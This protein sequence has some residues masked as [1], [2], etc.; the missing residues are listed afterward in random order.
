[1]KGRVLQEKLSFFLKRNHMFLFILYFA[2]LETVFHISTIGGMWNW[3]GI[4]ILLFSV[5]Y[6]VVWLILGSFI[7]HPV[8]NRIF[9]V[10]LLIAGAFPYGVLYFIYCKFHVFYNLNTVFGGAADAMGGF[11]S[12]IWELIL[13]V[14]GITH[15]VLL[16]LP[17]VLYLIFGIRKDYAQVISGR[18]RVYAMVFGMV[19]FSVAMVLVEQ[20]DVAQASFSEQ[21]SYPGAVEQFGLITGMGLDIQHTTKE[22]EAIDF[23]VEEIVVETQVESSDK[24][25]TTELSKEQESIEY[26]KNVLDIDFEALAKDAPEGLAVLDEYVASLEPSSKNQYTGMFKGKN[27][28]FLTA[29]AFSA[30]VIDEKL[31]PTLY[32]MATKGI[33][34]T[35]YYQPASAGTTG[36][37]YSNIMGLLPTAG[38]RSM[39]DTAKNLNYMTIGSQLNRLGYYGK[40]YHNNDYKYY[41][42]DK[43]HVTLGYSDGYM[44]YGNG[45]EEYVTNQWPESDLEMI[46]GT[47]PTYVNKQPFN[48][49]YMTVSGHSNYS[50]GC[51]A[52]AKK[53]QEQV[54]SLE[55]SDT[56]K[57]YFACQLELEDALTYLVDEL[58]KAGIAEDT[59]I[60]IATDHFPYGLDQNGNSGKLPYL[61]ELYGCDI[62]DDFVKDHNRLILWSECLEKDEPIVVSE[63]TFSPDIVPTLCNL[64]GVEYDSR[65]L[66]GRDVLSDAQPLVFNLGYDWKTDKGTYLAGKNRFTPV[67][68]TT[69]IPEDYVENMKTIVKNKINYCKGVLKQDY[70]SHVFSEDKGGE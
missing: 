54:V 35:D 60:C 29:E 11:S 65:L 67:S 25:E 24:E 12:D 33:N 58:E 22:G 66:P 5:V 17:C 47:L 2:Y 56:V 43:T 18:Q 50:F 38:G 13:S 1:M 69:Y 20:N 8:W 4:Y 41:D 51:N 6:G 28:I 55:Y 26:G 32:R 9:K 46:Q 3:S 37:E 49:Y 52:M 21:Y 45:I 7:S 57:A 16:L 53:H 36:G 62:T 68:E 64:F 70:F 14:D 19:V 15:L 48:I 61:S 63:P 39:K 59:V 40:M 10:L 34:F 23:A 30:E 44:G 31:T 42:R 27:L